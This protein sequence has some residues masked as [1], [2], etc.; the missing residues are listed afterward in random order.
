MTVSRYPETP[1]FGK[2]FIEAA[3]ELGFETMG[4]ATGRNQTQFT[5]AQMTVRN[6]ERLTTSKAFLYPSDVL[7]RKNLNIIPNAYVRLKII[8]LNQ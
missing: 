1:S 7:S 6:G 4:D 3:R 8:L 5:I 2:Y